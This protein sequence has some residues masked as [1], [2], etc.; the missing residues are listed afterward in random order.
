M[1][2]LERL[3]FSPIGYFPLPEHC[4]LDNYYRPLQRR[5]GDFL[6]RHNNSEAA[7][8]IVAAEEREM[9]LYERHKAFVSYGVYIARK[10]RPEKY[11]H[12]RSFS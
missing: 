3:G 7:R 5:F 8:T 1:A 4:W 6:D 11:S 12:V 9:S 10:N 2:I